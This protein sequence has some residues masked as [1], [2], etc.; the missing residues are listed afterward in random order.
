MHILPN[1]Q[2]MKTHVNEDCAMVR[3]ACRYQVVGCKFEVSGLSHFARMHV[4][5]FARCKL[6]YNYTI[7]KVATQ[8]TALI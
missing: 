6:Q 4:R 1:T 7:L 3:R 2:Q 8:Y 5:L